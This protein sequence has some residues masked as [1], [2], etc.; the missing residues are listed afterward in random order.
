VV[1]IGPAAGRNGGEVVYSGSAQ[2]LRKHQESITGAYLSGKL[3]IPTPSLRR[4]TER[5]ALTVVGA[6]ANNLQGIDVPFPLGTLTVVSGVSGSGKST[7]VNDG[8]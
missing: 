7:L 4:T 2:D 5:G 3:S 1:E 6:T 8:C